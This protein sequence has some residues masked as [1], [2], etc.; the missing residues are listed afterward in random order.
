MNFR[1]LRNEM[2]E[3]ALC[4]EQVM[5]QHTRISLEELAEASNISATV[6]AFIL[7]QMQVFCIVNRVSFGRYSLTPEYLKTQR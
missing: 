1:T 3:Q 7:E 5:R 6:V 4:I 2:T